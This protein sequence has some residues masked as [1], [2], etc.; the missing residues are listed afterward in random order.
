MCFPCL[1]TQ[2]PTPCRPST[3][4]YSLPV[5][6]T[7]PSRCRQP[8][9]L[10]PSCLPSFVLLV[11][12]V[13]IYSWCSDDGIMWLTYLNFYLEDTGLQVCGCGCACC[14]QGEHLYDL[15]V[16]VVELDPS[17]V[18]VAPHTRRVISTTP[19]ISVSFYTIYSSTIQCTPTIGETFGAPRWRP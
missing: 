10:T 13:C 3:I 16:V 19:C 1:L 11:V 18:S 17:G 8:S 4:G 12:S 14:T 6:S 2:V 7:R 5:C 15:E 9:K